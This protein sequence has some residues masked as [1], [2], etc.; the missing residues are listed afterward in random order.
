MKYEAVVIG[1]SAGGMNALS[2]VLSRLPADFGLP[3]IIVQHMDPH[4]RDYLPNHLDRKCTITVKEAE[5]KEKIRSGVAYIAPPNYHLLLEEDRTFSLSVDDVVNF[6]RPSIDVMF[7]TAADVYNRK[8]VGVVLTGANA[9]GSK[10]L[11]KIKAMGGMAIVQDPMTAYVDVMPKAA[12]AI[13]KVDHV[14]PLEEIAVL[15]T[16]LSNSSYT[17]EMKL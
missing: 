1:V 14:L 8:L 6:S 15:L 12:I 5:D 7:E 9:D 13:T 10:G 2:T 16:E 4:S 3:V 11:K 17:D